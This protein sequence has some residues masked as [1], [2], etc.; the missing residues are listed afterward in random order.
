MVFAGLPLS[1]YFNAN[2]N[3]SSA[4]LFFLNSLLLANSDR[5]DQNLKNR[6]QRKHSYLTAMG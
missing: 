1:K 6:V 4:S 3:G 5:C 2:R